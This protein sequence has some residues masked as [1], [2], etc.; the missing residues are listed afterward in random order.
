MANTYTQLIIHTVFAVK[1]RQ[2]LIDKTW[3]QELHDYISTVIN[4][5]GH[6]TL[7]INGVEDY[8]H[9][10]FG[11]KPT[12]SISNTMRDIK[13]NS[14]KWL[15]ESGKLETRFAWQDGY[16]A[17]T[18]SKTHL[19]AIHKYIEIQEIHHQ[20]ITFKEEYITLLEKNEVVFEEKYLFEDLI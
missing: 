12:L 13:A 18:I 10:L 4:N 7:N 17:F 16:G 19:N 8:V 15:N 1:Y 14:S 6:K 2:A 9:I 3:K 20:K 5:M 11:M